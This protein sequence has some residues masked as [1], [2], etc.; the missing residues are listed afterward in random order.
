MASGYSAID[1]AAVMTNMLVEAHTKACETWDEAEHTY[2]QFL[3]A[4]L[5]MMREDY[6]PATGQRKPGLGLTQVNPT[7]R[8]IMHAGDDK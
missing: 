7:Y 8:T 5:A 6:S 3:N 1:V 2:R 4:G